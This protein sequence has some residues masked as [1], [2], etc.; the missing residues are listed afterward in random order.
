[1]KSRIVIGVICLF[2]FSSS[3]Q[4][5]GLKAFKLKNGLSVFIWEDP[6]QSDVYGAVG[7]RAGSVDDPQEYT[8]LAHY[9]EHVMFKGT[10]QIG[11]LDWEQ[12]KDMYAQIITK[13]DEMAEESDPIRKEEINK[14]IN[15]LTIEA[16]KISLPT[17]YSN[18]IEH[19][20]GT[21]LNAGTIYDYTVYYNTFPPFQI[22]KWLAISSERFIDPVFRSFQSE[23][24]TVYEEYNMYKDR[25]ASLINEFLFDKAFEGHPYSRPV[26]GLGEHLKNPRLSKLIEFYNTWYRPENMVLILV[27]NVDAQQVSRQIS[28]TFGRLEAGELPEHVN[29]GATP[30]KGRKTY[31]TKIS[32]QPSVI[33]AFNGVPAGHP[34]EIPL[35]ICLKLLHNNTSTGL[36]DK[37]TMDGDLMGAYAYPL[38]LRQQG[39]IV[40]QGYPLYDENQKRFASNKSVERRLLNSVEKIRNGE[41]ENRL[42]ES[43]KMEMCREY[44]L[45]LETNERIGRM[46]LDAFI[47]ERELEEI[48][49]YKE[50]VKNVSMD[51]IQKVAATYLT[52]DYLVINNERGK[53]DRK[54]RMQK[55][56]YDP[57]VPPVGQS[58]LYSQQLKALPI[59][60]IEVEQPSFDEVQI[61]TINERSKLYYTPNPES[62]IFSLRIKYGVG[63]DKMP[64]LGFAASLMNDAG[65]MG[66]YEPHEF[67]SVL[68]QLGATHFVFATDSYLY[69]DVKGYEVNLEEVCQL[70]TRQI[71]M[72]KL[73]EKQLR[74]LKGS[75]LGGRSTRKDNLNTLTRALSEFVIY[76]N[77]SSYI[78]SLTDKEVYDLQISELT[79]EINRASH[80]EAEIHY[81]GSLDFDTVYNKLSNSLPLIANELTTTSPEVTEPAPVTEHTVYFLPYTD[82]LQ[83][84]IYFYFPMDDYDHT[85]DVTI[86]AFTQYFGGGFN[87]LVLNEIREKNSMAYTA[88][89][90]VRRPPISAKKNYFM[91]YIGTQNDKA[92]DAIRLYKQLLSDMPEYPER[93]DNIKSYMRQLLLTDNPSVRNKSQVY[94]NM[95]KRGYQSYPSEVNIPEIEALSFEDIVNFYKQ[96]IQGKPMVIGIIGNP[97]DLDVD[98]LKEF[99]KVVRLDIRKLFNDKDKMF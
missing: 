46:L 94:E 35:E 19:L 70:I 96:N 45:G 10:S 27:G 57:I 9:L 85:Q 21:G 22:N 31:S 23:L 77:N 33:L 92:I 37:L 11:A 14:E 20:G 99:G 39:R 91:G 76:Q 43:I 61:K 36:L 44:D 38:T 62:E 56:S 24:E 87:G 86:E 93:M 4:A 12:E 3:T 71:L 64:K 28:A 63:T 90:L 84:N 60:Q 51:D 80:Y 30:I 78:N 75:E 89:G 52:N 2:L 98:A 17:E 88:Y 1:M 66:Q 97:R 25:P 81:T 6:S 15:R 73:D 83:S 59:N 55:P 53:P 74:S 79:G 42:I 13:Y 40:L 95:K 65:V 26:I 48:L 18:L 41:F 68:S 47:N 67:K 7:V 50:I 8:G 5:Q 49:E 16:G 72:P 69:I 32:P 82:A 54:H 34:D 58:S 29:Y